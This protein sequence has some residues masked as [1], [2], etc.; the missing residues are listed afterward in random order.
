M[1]HNKMSRML[2]IV[3]VFGII[4]LFLGLAIAGFMVP[5]KGSIGGDSYG[6]SG[7]LTHFGRFDGVFNPIDWTAV[8][9]A[10]NG[11]TVTT[12]TIDFV[13]DVCLDDP[14]PPDPADCEVSTYVQELIIT[15]GTGRFANA[16]GNATV[17]GVFNFVTG[18]FEGYLKGTISRPN[19]GR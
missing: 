17:E 6:F 9:T 16:I 15:G 2:Q 7:N 4:S 12:Q 8:Y 14:P 1:F 5:L 13:P 19:S 11:D 18:E 3:T 10:A